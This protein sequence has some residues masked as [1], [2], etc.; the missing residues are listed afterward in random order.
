MWDFIAKIFDTT[1]FPERW[2]CGLAWQQSPGVGWLHIISD[3]AT[4]AAYYAV[5][6]VVLY[7]VKRSKKVKFP[8]IFY[9]FLGL[10]F[11]SCG[12]VHLVEAG[13]FYWPVYRLSG[14][15]KL[16]TA[17]F[18]CIGVV[19][20]TRVLPAALELKSGKEYQHAVDERL[21]AEKSLEHERFLLHT[22]L[23]YL[24]DAI[25]FKD[26]QGKFTR[27]SRS[28]AKHLGT[29]TEEVVGKTD[30][31]FFDASYAAEAQA[32][33]EALMRT[34]KPLI[35]KEEQPGWSGSEV[36][37]VSTTKVPLPDNAGN[38]IGTFGVSHDIS[39]QKAVETNFRSVI[40][41][42]PNP[43]VVVNREGKIELVNSATS[44]V[45]GYAQSEL[46]G[47]SIEILVPERLRESHQELRKTYQRQPEARPMGGDRQLAGRRKDGSE[48]PLEIGLNPVRLND[49]TAVLASV[50]DITARKQ[51]QDALVAAKQAAESANQ[52][53]SDFLANMSHEIRTPMNAIIGMTEMVLSDDLN[54]D[55]RGYLTTVLES[56]ES[57]LA[58]INEILDFSKIE[59]GHLHL[60]NVEFDL[61]DEI[62]DALRT[63]S[64]RAFRK[65]LELACNVAPDVPNRCW[66][67]PIR[68]RQIIINLVGNAIKFTESGEIVVDVSQQGDSG[69]E[70]VFQV[71][72][73]DTGVGIPEDRLG[74]I[75]SAFAQADGSTTRRF[76]GTGLGLTISSRLVEAMHGKI[77]VE[78]QVGQGS[79]FSF[80]IQLRVSEN[81]APAALDLQSLENCSV[82]VVDD[83]ATN[84]K[85]LQAMLQSWKMKVYVVDG[86]QSALAE[87]ERLAQSGNPPLLVLTDVQMPGMDGFMLAAKIRAHPRLQETRIVLLSSGVRASDTADRERL[88]IRAQLMKPIKRSELLDVILLSLGGMRSVQATSQ[89]GE[90]KLPELDSLKILLVEDG[91]ANQ[92]LALGLL[93]RWGHQVKLAENGR[94][95]VESWQSEEF[96]LILMDLQ[97]PEMDGFEATRQIRSLEHGSGRHIPIVAMTAHAMKGDEER[98]LQAGMDGYVPK[99]I[100]QK[101]LHEALSK[102]LSTGVKMA[103]QE[104]RSPSDE[105]GCVDW[106]LVLE[107]VGGDEGF[108]KSIIQACLE[109]TPQLVQQLARSLDEGDAKE[110]RRLAH[111]IKAAGRTFGV[112]RL[113][114]HAEHIELAA[115]SGDLE[116]SRQHFP[117]LEQMVKQMAIELQQRLDK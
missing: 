37:W 113:T 31:D 45:F 55:H 23:D 103:T 59:A 112:T 29:T 66:G 6:I 49:R 77:W 9:V 1:G 44:S 67:D 13:I 56:A 79:T 33:E 85:I 7:Y 68:I 27:V 110:S 114:E 40:D 73:R 93:E 115:E 100:R 38:I 35:G 39:A 46:I 98:C 80:T 36:T 61:R 18:S 101:D 109:E 91:K 81:A 64:S 47:Q 21:K 86:G 78:S 53:K 22:L 76:G 83:N 71:S 88:G 90:A 60:E 3:V 32:D 26:R 87:L 48:F 69:T 116:A 72:V 10:I 20:L 92:M 63:L 42:A 41:A 12:T 111:T 51:T 16:L 70:R 107:T 108:L 11:F 89:A 2:Q 24:P 58:I 15:L 94:E 17:T 14:V 25:Y 96:D 19:I 84:R 4:F 54:S 106:G 65:G 57:L 95:A 34:G 50:I 43:L 75:F 52:A 102:F 74:T 62:S 97:M 82:L 28:L 5:P 105:I 30:R 8:L 99:P 104:T 117:G